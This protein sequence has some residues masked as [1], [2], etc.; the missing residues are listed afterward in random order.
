MKKQNRHFALQ[1]TIENLNE[2]AD[3]GVNTTEKQ[4]TGNATIVFHIVKKDGML[5]HKRIAEQS[6][7]SMR[8]VQRAMK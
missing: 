1:E 5:T 3:D 4:L 8:S 2:Q 7:L 6:S